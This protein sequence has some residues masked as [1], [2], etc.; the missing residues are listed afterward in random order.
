MM[1][2]SVETLGELAA[3]LSRAGAP[4]ALGGRIAGAVDPGVAAKVGQVPARDRD[5]ADIALLLGGADPQG[6][7]CLYGVEAGRL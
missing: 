3:D 1:S 6:S 7:Q 5:W 4:L 2:R